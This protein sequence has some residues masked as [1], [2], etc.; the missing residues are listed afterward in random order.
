[1]GV[2]KEQQSDHKRENGSPE[3][4]A[5]GG[6]SGQHGKFGCYLGRFLF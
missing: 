5:R 6:L 2:G 4:D 1:M 3:P